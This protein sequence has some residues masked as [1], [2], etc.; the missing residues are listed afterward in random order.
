MDPP[1]NPTPT[2]V[3]CVKWTVMVVGLCSFV[4]DFR[5]PSPQP[6]DQV[7]GRLSPTRGEGVLYKEGK[8]ELQLSSHGVGEDLQLVHQF[9]EPMRFEGFLAVAEGAFRIRMNL[10]QK[11]V[12][13]RRNGRLSH[14]SHQIP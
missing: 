6:P 1:I 9:L 7:R 5:P 10:D 3:T 4:D 12:G 8:R 14:G 11:P 13:T 2:I